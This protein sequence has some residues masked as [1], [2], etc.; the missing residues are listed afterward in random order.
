MFTYSA[1]AT[2]GSDGLA[3]VGRDAKQ[4]GAVAPRLG[5]VYHA[6]PDADFRGFV[7]DMRDYADEAQR[8]TVAV[9]LGDSALR[10]SQ[11]INRASRAGRPDMQGTHPRR[12]ALA[13]GCHEEVWP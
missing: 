6:A 7:D 8:V 2:V 4:P 3:M 5:E 13:A 10:L 11:V 12:D 1:G 9:N